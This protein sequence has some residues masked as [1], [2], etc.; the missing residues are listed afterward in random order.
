MTDL[1]YTFGKAT[2]RWLFGQAVSAWS[3]FGGNTYAMAK[4]QSRFSL[5]D[6]LIPVQVAV[7]DGTNPDLTADD[8]SFQFVLG[9]LPPRAQPTDDGWLTGFWLP[10]QTGPLLAGIL[11]GPSGTAE[12]AV[13]KWAVWVKVEDNPTI[14]VQAVDVLTIN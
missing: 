5:D 12:L 2:P 1:L 8:V 4:T 3:P 9:G 11:V 10:Q 7:P 13:G 6:F 14:P